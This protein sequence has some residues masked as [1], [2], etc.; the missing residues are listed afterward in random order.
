MGGRKMIKCVN[1]EYIEMTQEEIENLIGEEEQST[2]KQPTIEERLEK[3]EKF[4]NS[5]R[6]LF[7]IKG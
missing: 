5:I 7:N 3:V 4:A 6:D 2:I 1:G